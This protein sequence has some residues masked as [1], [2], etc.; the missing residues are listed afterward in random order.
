[1]Q[2]AMP[3]MIALLDSTRH[4]REELPPELGVTEPVSGSVVF[5]G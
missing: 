3:S 1:M 2:N 4:L 5:E